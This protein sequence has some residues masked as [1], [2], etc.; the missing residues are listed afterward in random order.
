MSK[1]ILQEKSYLFAIRAV[2][3]S[4][5]LTKEK[6]EFTLSRKLLDSG[7]AIG[8]FIEEA[9]QG[10]SRGDFRSKLSVANKEAFKTNFLLRLLHDVD[11]ITKEQFDSIIGDCV[12]LQKMLI[13]AL[14]TTQYSD[15]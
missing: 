2:K 1:S 7:S 12:E 9:R 6:R 10:D 5:Y 8:L 14:K 11:L 13:S 3:L 15:T 4:R